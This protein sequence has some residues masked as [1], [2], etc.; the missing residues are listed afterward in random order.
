MQELL[1][2]LDSL[3]ASSTDIASMMGAL[4]A[5]FETLHYGNVRNTDKSMIASI[6]ET[7]FYRISAGLEHSCH[8]IAYDE[9]QQLTSRIRPVH[10]GLSLL[11]S[12]PL[13]EVWFESLARTVANSHTAG[14]I[15]GVC[16]KILYDSQRLSEQECL[17]AMS[18][19]LSL[20]GPAEYSAQWVEGFFLDGAHLLLYDTA[21]WSVVQLWLN[22]LSDETFIE[23]LPM[24]RRTFEQYEKAEKEKIAQKIV[25]QQGQHGTQPVPTWRTPNPTRSQGAII[26][27]EQLLFPQSHGQ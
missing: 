3:A 22:S 12:T 15:H 24:L 23:L 19:A 13:Q 17:A 20:S 1:R 8:G 10:T 9:A 21:V 2:Q 25:K 27:L 4:P 11:Q 16:T 14:I 6:V 18:K 26:A 7:I 5:L